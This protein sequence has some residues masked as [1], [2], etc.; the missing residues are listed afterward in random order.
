MPAYNCNYRII[1]TFAFNYCLLKKLA[2]NKFLPGVFCLI[3]ESV[4]CLSNK[5]MSNLEEAPQE[6][7]GASQPMQAQAA[8]PAPVSADLENQ[9]AVHDGFGVAAI[10]NKWNRDD[11][12]KRASWAL[13][14]IALLFSLV[15]FLV[16]ACNKH[17]GWENFDNYEEYQ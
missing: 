2:I 13:R 5:L 16:M 3:N 9:R 1:T 11:K 6:K 7:A 8:G 14:G 12:L 4:L 10:V 17:G 15:S